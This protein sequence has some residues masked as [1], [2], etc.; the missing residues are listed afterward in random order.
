[1]A[2]EINCAECGANLIQ[3]ESGELV[4]NGTTVQEHMEQTPHQPLLDGHAEPRY[5]SELTRDEHRRRVR[6]DWG[7]HKAERL[8]DH[9]ILSDDEIVIA[10][11]PSHGVK[12]AVPWETYNTARFGS[13][14][15]A[16]VQDKA[17]EKLI[18]RGCSP[19]EA[20]DYHMT[21]DQDLSQSDWAR[22]RGV[23]PQTVSENV[24]K[25]REK[26]AE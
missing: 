17:V 4:V 21:V 5:V 26:L 1:M 10:G 19:A 6:E 11:H 12:M 9:P 16:Q 3:P 18:D 25:A 14:S 13:E 15:E 7:E 23:T 2:R 8:P 22:Q 20:L 24:A